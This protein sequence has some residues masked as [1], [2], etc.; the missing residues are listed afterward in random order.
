MTRCPL[1]TALRA[2][3]F[4]RV[5][6]TYTVACCTLRLLPPHTTTATSIHPLPSHTRLTLRTSYTF[7]GLRYPRAA[8]LFALR[9]V[10]MPAG[11]SFLRLSRFTLYYAMY[12]RSVFYNCVLPPAFRPDVCRLTYVRCGSGSCRSRWLH[13]PVDDYQFRFVL[14][15]KISARRVLSSPLFSDTAFPFTALPLTC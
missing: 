14:L 10:R 11:A 5:A 7:C 6:S 12:A 3:A 8:H 1:F 13:S 4:S 9:T 2:S 15:D